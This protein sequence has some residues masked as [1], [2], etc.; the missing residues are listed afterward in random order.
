MAAIGRPDP[1][2]AELYPD[3]E[4]LQILDERAP[5]IAV[6]FTTGEYVCMTP[7]MINTTKV[8]AKHIMLGV[9]AGVVVAGAVIGVRQLVATSVSS[10]VSAIQETAVS[11]IRPVAE[12]TITKAALKRAARKGL[13]GKTFIRRKTMLRVARKAAL[14]KGTVV[15]GATIND[16]DIGTRFLNYLGIN[17]QNLSVER[18]LTWAGIAGGTSNVV[19]RGVLRF[20]EIQREVRE[21]SKNIANLLQHLFREAVAEQIICL[22]DEKEDIGNMRDIDRELDVFCPISKKLMHIPVSTGCNVQRDENGEKVLDEDGNLVMLGDK[23]VVDYGSLVH[24][25]ERN[26][27]CPYP[28][29]ENVINKKDILFEPGVRRQIQK[30]TQIAFQWITARQPKQVDLS[31]TE[32]ILLDH[33]AINWRLEQK[34]LTEDDL[35]FLSYLF[36]KEIQ[37]YN[38]KVE[39]FSNDISDKIKCNRQMST[40]D[41]NARKNAI[42]QIENTFLIL[43]PRAAKDQSDQKE[44][45]RV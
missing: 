15:A 45:E 43:F 11:S 16:P 28:G 32:S 38:D 7:V 40:E 44:Q 35:A 9:A 8:G 33:E 23:H 27:R 26:D 10:S 29:C 41:R 24:H 12:G 2:L 34:S 25:L 4:L 42:Q 36:L 13:F 18:A 5:E 22:I 17:P 1:N 21:T 30:V 39:S 3:M 31:D 19:I 20:P 14:S 6:N 37:K